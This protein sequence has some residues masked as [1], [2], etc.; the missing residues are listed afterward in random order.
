MVEMYRR[1]RNTLR[2]L[3]ANVSDFDPASSICVPVEQWVELDRYALAMT[4]EL[5]AAVLHDYER[6]EF[7]FVMQKLHIFCSEYL[8]AFYLDILKDRLYTT[9]AR[10]PCATLRAERAVPHHATACCACSRRC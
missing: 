7:H 3:L 9:G 5:Q 4:H 6:Y 10:E 1:I 8:G 2:F